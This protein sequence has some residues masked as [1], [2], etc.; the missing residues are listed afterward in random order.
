MRALCPS[1]KGLREKYEQAIVD[2]HHAAFMEHLK[3][4]GPY[5]KVLTHSPTHSLT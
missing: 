3:T 1:T 2:K 5:Y 4:M